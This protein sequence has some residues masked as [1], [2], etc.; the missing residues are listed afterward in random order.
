[1][2][3]AF[4]EREK[5][6]HLIGVDASASAQSIVLPVGT[7]ESP[8]SSIEVVRLDSSSY[9]ALVTD[10]DGV[11]HNLPHRGSS[12]TLTCDGRR[13]YK[14][15]SEAA[16][17]PESPDHVVRQFI[18]DSRYNSGEWSNGNGT[19]TEVEITARGLIL[20][21]ELSSSGKMQIEVNGQL[22]VSSGS[23]GTLT[24]KLYYSTST[25]PVV[26]LGD[27][28]AWFTDTVT[29]SDPA[30]GSGLG[31]FTWTITVWPLGDYDTSNKQNWQSSLIYRRH[32]TD[33]V[34]QSLNRGAS[35]INLRSD[36]IVAVTGQKSAGWS[37]GRFNTYS[38]DGYIW[39]G[40]SGH[41]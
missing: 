33:T 1:M 4:N 25:D 39:N 31:D 37:T 40:D 34:Q 38:I 35:T 18:K 5:R 3:E 7:T 21:R 36:T 9:A 27:M 12:V 10:G 26:A 20:A 29:I 13:Q 41:A 8:F 23:S 15:S 30:G 14:R 11:A 22:L 24:L 16:W 19:T 6:K 17:A 32:S 28:T 2:A